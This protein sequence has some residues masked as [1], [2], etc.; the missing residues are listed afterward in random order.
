LLS[1]R[2]ADQHLGPLTDLFFHQPAS[3][4][5]K[6]VSEALDRRM[7]ALE[8]K[9]ES[10]RQVAVAYYEL[11]DFKQAR[12]V[13][14]QAAKNRRL[15]MLKLT[16]PKRRRQEYARCYLG[17]ERR[18]YVDFERW[19]MMMTQRECADGQPPELA[20]VFLNE[21]TLLMGRGARPEL[22]SHEAEDLKKY[23]TR[24]AR[25]VAFYLGSLNDEQA[26]FAA[27]NENAQQ[28][29]ILYWEPA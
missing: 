7:A 26:A 15:E 5:P 3:A 6:W 14:V 13:A 20:D 9:I 28:D 16:D 25:A 4:D 2:F 27:K 23:T 8:P 17:Y 24:C 10:D 22:P 19:G 12:W 29:D 11:K 21:Y 18:P 1:H